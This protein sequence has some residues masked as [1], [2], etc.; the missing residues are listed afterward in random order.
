M[1]HLCVSNCEAIKTLALKGWSRRRIAREL[2]LDRETVGRH[3]GPAKPAIP[4][5]GSEGS[6]DSKPAIPP[7]GSEAVST[8]VA[9]GEVLP[10]APASAAGRRSQCETYR[11]AIELAAEQGLSAQRIYQDLVSGHAF[12]GSYTAVKRFVRRLRAKI[13]LPF[14]RWESDP[15]EEAQIDFGQGA[16]V[17]DG[18]TGK[19]R[20][21]HLLRVILSHSRKGYSEA[22]W[23]QTTEEFI[24]GLENSFRA[25]G[26]VPAKLVVDNLRAA[27]SRVDWF[28]P[29]LNPKVRE[30]CTHYGTAMLPTRPAMPR[31]KGKVESGVKYG[32]NNALKGRQFASLAA[33]NLHLQEWERTVADTR[34]HGTTRRQV[35]QQFRDVEKPC[36][37]ALPAGLFPV[38]SE[39][40]RSVH[41]DGHVELLKA[42]Y[43]VP[44]EYLGQQVWVRRE[45]RLVRIFD[46]RMQPIALHAR[47][48]PGRFSTDQTHLHSHKRSS[49]EKGVA[50]MLGRSA[51]MGDACGMWTAKMYEVRGVEGIRVLQGFLGLADDHP[52]G[53]IERAAQRAL[54]QGAWRLRELKALL[55][56]PSPQLSLGFLES[57]PLIRNLD[58]YAH[59]TPDCFD[60]S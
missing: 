47:V 36:L 29:E 38:F 60:N 21:P 1:N 24:R 32:Q 31:H 37:R 40:R 25:F 49:I 53:A 35:G 26:G 22:I 15:G 6:P 34:L 10:R 4:A 23:R 48:D 54:D 28:E 51:L 46:E 3:L 13:E 33:Q 8:G 59:L 52:I 30:F 56:E 16:W 55:A 43:S 27:V 57:H 50:W 41:R 58:A 2:G 5:V 39:G 14:R 19:R 17:M 45:A 18:E 42:Y 11:G 7:S 44:P 9:D 12:A 20:R